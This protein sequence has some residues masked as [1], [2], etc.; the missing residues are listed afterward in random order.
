MGAGSGAFLAVAAAL[1]W[2]AVGV[3][4]NPAAAARARAAGHD[5]RTGNGED[6]TPLAGQKVDY[7]RFHHV[8]EHMAY[9]E[10]ALSNAAALAAPGARLLVAVPNAGGLGAR[11]F[12][13]Y[14]YH[15]AVPFH[16]CHFDPRTLTALL[17]A[18][19]WLPEKVYAVSSI[20]GVT[21][22]YV[23]FLKDKAGVEL[24]PLPRVERVLQTLLRPLLFVV[25]LCLLGDNVVVEATRTP[26]AS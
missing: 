11:V 10:K 14:W 20:Q 12:R 1:G 26:D 13:G 24:P 22:S 25:D 8:L 5:V 2:R 15:W 21:R 19:G 3:E 16:R 6:L 18:T 9:P 23:A 7:F 17:K 4:Q